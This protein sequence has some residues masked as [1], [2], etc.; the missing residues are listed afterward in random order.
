MMMTIMMTMMMIMMINNDATS[1]PNCVGILPIR[2]LLNSAKYV[3]LVIIP[4]DDGI[5]P[6]KLLSY[7][8]RNVVLFSN[9]I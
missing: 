4:N 5:D 1:L 9:P 8:L 2:L 3:S 7:R 6:V